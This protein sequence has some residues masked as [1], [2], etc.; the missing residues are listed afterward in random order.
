MN[1]YSSLND[2]K[3]ELSHNKEFMSFI[4]D[5]SRGHCCIRINDDITFVIFRKTIDDAYESYVGS[6]TNITSENQRPVSIFAS[7]IEQACRDL[8]NREH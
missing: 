4:E 8:H 3:D 7:N 5:M 6:C 2:I 1:L